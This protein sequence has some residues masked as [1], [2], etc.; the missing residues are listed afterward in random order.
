MCAYA[1]SR[2]NTN[3]SGDADARVCPA[4]GTRLTC[5]RTRGS[6]TSSESAVCR[7]ETVCVLFQPAS[8][9]HMPSLSTAYATAE[10]ARRCA[11]FSH[12]SSRGCCQIRPPPRLEARATAASAA[13][14]AVSFPVRFPFRT[15]LELFLWRPALLLACDR[16]HHTMCFFCDS[17]FMLCW[18]LCSRATW[19]Y[20]GTITYMY[21]CM[22]IV[23]QWLSN[24]AFEY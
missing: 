22:C 19:I 18:F 24:Q 14:A 3:W 13:A 5:C 23:W 15:A 4:R 17:L 21:T 8:A 9:L 20:L 16:R 1:Y 2:L 11:L 10:R 7:G 12:C 6:E